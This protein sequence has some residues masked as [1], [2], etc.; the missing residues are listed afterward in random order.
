MLSAHPLTC[1][2][3]RS[4]MTHYSFP[5]ISDA[6]AQELTLIKFV[7]DIWHCR[8]CAY[9]VQETRNV[10]TGTGHRYFGSTLKDEPI[11]MLN[12]K[13]RWKEAPALESLE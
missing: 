2:Q 6:A 7:I 8:L 5:N 1:R 4:S 13:I 9:G 3:C 11:D 12:R 10:Y